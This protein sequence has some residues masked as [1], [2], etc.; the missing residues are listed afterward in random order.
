MSASHANASDSAPPPGRVMRW[1]LGIS[2]LVAFALGI[3][4]HLHPSQHMSFW[5]AFYHTAQL[6]AMHSPH[7]EHVP[8]QLHCARLLAGAT[9][10]VAGF[11]FFRHL[12][13]AEVADMRLG[14]MSGHVVVCGL[15]RKGMALVRH[16][17]GS[18]HDVV[19]I[20][21]APSAEAAAC[22]RAL[23][24]HL[25]AGNAMNPDVL[26][27][28]RVTH[29]RQ[30]IAICPQDGTNCE[31]GAQ[32]YRLRASAGGSDETACCVHVSDSEAR[33]ALQELLEPDGGTPG[34]RVR[35]FDCFDPEARR[36]V[37][38]ELPIDH[39]GVRPG[40]PRRVHLIVLG[41]GRMGRALVLR[42]AQL[43]VFAN[44]TRIRISIIDRRAHTR[45]DE[46]LF[47]H[48]GLADACDVEFHETDIASPR[49]RTLLAQWCADADAITSVA[50][51][52]DNEQQALH[53]ALPLRRIAAGRSA[54][55]AVRMPGHDGVARF[56]EARAARGAAAGMF[57]CFG[58]EERVAETGAV[59]E[60]AGERLTRQMHEA[61]RKMRHEEPSAN[62]AELDKDRAMKAWDEL[63]EDLRESNRQQRAH[64]AIK[65][66]AVDCEIVERSDPRPALSVF[67]D[68][69]VDLLAELEHRRWMTEKLIAGWTHAPGDKNEQRRTSPHLVP[70]AGLSD[71]VREYDRA[72]IRSIPALMDLT[73]QKVCR[74]ADDAP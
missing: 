8:W 56:L 12:W 21:S 26:R 49:T 73:G 3:A 54:R 51:C 37:A 52:I 69:E 1:C 65:M 33:Q 10:I 25:I 6:F 71:K 55:V 64:L 19:A 48:P 23:G 17:R 58:M 59:D 11:R 66:R 67:A 45:R 16:L 27:A 35:F 22:C 31:I 39:D 46:L 43:G 70:W 34:A 9:T 14:R 50:V 24:V 7:L 4:G 68:A 32:V 5:D 2:S 61:Y 47:H 38:T 44:G 62:R 18:D 60:D 28:A 41:L 42:A 63:D 57:R 36:L 13:R 29:A 53:I 20:E 40:D 74:R 72:T 15:G 30:V